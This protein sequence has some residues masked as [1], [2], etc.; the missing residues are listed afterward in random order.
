MSTTNPYMVPMPGYPPWL[1]Y[2]DLRFPAQGINPAGGATPP[3]VDAT[4][5]PGTLLFPTNVDSF[6]A[7]VAQMPHAW[8]EGSDVYPHIHWT[9]TTADA[10]AEAVA[11]RFRYAVCGVGAALGSYSSD[12]VGTLVVGDL[13][14]LERHN[15]T[16]F[17]VISMT[18]E[19]VSTMILWQIFRDISED[20]YGNDARLLEV[21]FHYIID[22]AG[23][24]SLYT[25]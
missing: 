24:D 16:S 21:D 9:K 15:V 6:I 11:W 2:E 17:P 25:K 10:G 8:K 1:C 12:Q 4:T 23:S 20:N 7:G 5:Y 22:S 14:T 3:T 18:G 13:T 19:L